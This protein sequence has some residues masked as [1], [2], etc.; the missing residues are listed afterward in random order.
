MR[1]AFVYTGDV[2]DTVEQWPD[3]FSWPVTISSTSLHQ[4]EPRERVEK[5]TGS[6]SHTAESYRH[7]HLPDAVRGSASF[8]TCERA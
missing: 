5:V 3:C 7:L 4:V 1:T 8:P 2:S 6:W